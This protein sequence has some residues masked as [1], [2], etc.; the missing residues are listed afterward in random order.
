MANSASAFVFPDCHPRSVFDVGTQ[1]KSF[2]QK[3][4]QVRRLK[5]HLEIRRVEEL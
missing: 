2:P 5:R 3:V 4:K 1:S